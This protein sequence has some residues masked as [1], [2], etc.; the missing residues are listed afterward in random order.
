MTIFGFSWPS[1]QRRRT[2]FYFLSA[3]TFSDH[4]A[5]FHQ[6]QKYV[7][8]QTKEIIRRAAT[9]KLAYMES[10]KP[11]YDPIRKDWE[12]VRLSVMK[13]ALISKFTQY[14]ELGALLISTGNR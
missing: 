4:I 9:P 8:T 1:V 3:L 6:A 10:F 14:P 7:G 11:Q 12:E 5:D 13:T 2:S